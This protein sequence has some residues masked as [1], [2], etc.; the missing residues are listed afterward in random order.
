[1]S[2]ATSLATT[3]SGLLT[4]AIP[5][6]LM[7]GGEQAY[8]EASKKIGSDSWELAKKIWA[9]ITFS[10]DTDHSKFPE[11]I[12][13]AANDV[14]KN[15]LDDDAVSALRFQIRQLLKEDLLIANE[16][17]G[18]LSTSLVTSGDNF[19]KIKGVHVSKSTLINTG[20]IIGGDS[21]V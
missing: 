12:R 11:L 7:K 21:G 9:K 19:T 18:I 5:Y 3:V 8:L 20:T 2:D 1:M 15:P 17:Q 6:L 16:L 10:S 4:P 13:N 14:L